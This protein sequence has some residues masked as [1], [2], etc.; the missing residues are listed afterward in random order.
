VQGHIRLPLSFRPVFGG[1]VSTIS[2][3]LDELRR[4]TCASLHLAGVVSKPWESHTLALFRFSFAIRN[5]G[6]EMRNQSITSGLYTR[7]ERFTDARI[8]GGVG[9]GRGRKRE[10][11]MIFAASLQ[12]QNCSSFAWHAPRQEYARCRW[13]DSARTPSYPYKSITHIPRY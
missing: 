5:L 13:R 11:E 7:D 6:R 8:H 3:A 2:A 12:H 1:R 9:E 4:F 10:P